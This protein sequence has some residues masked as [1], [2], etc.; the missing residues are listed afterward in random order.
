MY[1]RAYTYL[2]S[3][4][5]TPYSTVLLEKLTGLQLVKKF[6]AFYGTRK[7]ITVFTSARHLSLSWAS[8]IQSILP[9][10]TSWRSILIFSQFPGCCCK[11]AC[12]IQA[13]NVPSTKSPVPLSLLTS[14]QSISRGPR[15]CLWKF[16]NKIRFLQRGVVSTSSNIQYGGPP[17]VSCSRLLIQYIRSYPP[18][19]E[20]VLPSATWRRAMPW[21]QGPTY[22]MAV[23]D[24]NLYN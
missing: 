1:V 12:P 14:N 7:F 6:P 10:P 23:R 5:L 21:W 24:C 4:L 15:L 18:Y 16:R 20:A 19:L 9:H 3:Y 8:S 17:L 22:H 2:L 11:W 13:P